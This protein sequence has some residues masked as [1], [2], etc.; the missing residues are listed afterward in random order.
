MPHGLHLE[1]SEALFKAMKKKKEKT[2]MSYKDIVELSLLHYLDLD[3]PEVS[4]EDMN[5]LLHSMEQ[6][7]EILKKFMG[8]VN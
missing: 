4:K 8:E 2:G 1:I 3:N 7:L 6:Q 5:Q